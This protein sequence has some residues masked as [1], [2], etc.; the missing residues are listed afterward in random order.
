MSQML[1]MDVAGV[2]QLAQLMNQKAE[3]INGAMN[4][5]TGQLNS[6][7]WVGN[8]ANNFRSEWDGSHRAALQQVINSLRDA[9]TK[10][11]KNADEQEQASNS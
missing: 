1:G 6:V 4:E 7:Q 11:S 8:D 2:R 3:E 10:A 9:S 5:I